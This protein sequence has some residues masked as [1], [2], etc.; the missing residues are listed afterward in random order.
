M[1]AIFRP[2]SQSPA[3]F[4][5]FHHPSLR[6]EDAKTTME[7]KSNGGLV[8]DGCHLSAKCCLLL[9]TIP[10]QE[11]TILWQ[12]SNL[13]KVSHPTEIY[14]KSMQAKNVRHFCAAD[15]DLKGWSANAASPARFC[16]RVSVKLGFA[17]KTD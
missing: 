11:N 15:L 6:G 14:R 3:I 7:G 9:P 10:V 2:S 4:H 13:Q 16:G 17:G 12:K 1:A 8:L 5:H